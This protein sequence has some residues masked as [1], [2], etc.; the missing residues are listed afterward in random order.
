MVSIDPYETP[1]SIEAFNSQAGVAESLPTALDG[2]NAAR[3]FG[4]SALEAPST[5]PG[6]T[7]AVGAE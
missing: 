2:G 4:V 3:E 6:L 1:Q 7:R 5:I